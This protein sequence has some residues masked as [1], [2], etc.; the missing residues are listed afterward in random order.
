MLY[1]KD[2]NWN[3]ISDLKEMRKNASE[4]YMDLVGEGHCD[5]ECIVELHKDLLKLSDEQSKRIDSGLQLKELSEAVQKLSTGKAPGLDGLPAEFYKQFWNLLK[6]DLYEVFNN[7]NQQHELPTS[8]KRAVLSLLPKKGDLG[9]LKNW[10]PVAV[11][12]TDYKI[13]AKC[14]S[15]R[16]KPFLECMVNEHQIYCI[17]NRT[18][19]DDLFL[20][21][22]IID[23][24]SLNGEH[25]GI[26]AVDQEKAFDRVSHFICL[27]H[28]KLLGLGRVS[29]HGL[30][31]V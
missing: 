1:L 24:A 8:C 7:C 12:C 27:K 19:M 13:L 3:V 25:F 4:F 15:N 10:R 31:V 17:P 22:D 6:D 18:I 28:L 11:L 20:V 16:L 29:S 21:R 14:L 23:I 30:N 26:F 9:L 5:V 2:V